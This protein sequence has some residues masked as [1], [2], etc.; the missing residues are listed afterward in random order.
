[1]D[2]AE[3]V[4]QI[5]ATRNLTLYSVSQQSAQIFGRSSRFYVP[6]NLYY[7]LADPSFTPT[8]HQLL[9]LS[10]ITNYRLFDWLAALGCDLEQ[11]PRLRLLIR[12]QRTTL[13]DSSVYDLFTWVPWFAGTT[14]GAP[15]LP[16]APLRRFMSTASPK[17]AMELLALNK[18]RFLYGKVGEADPYALP[19]LA[20]GSVVR[21]DPARTQSGLSGPG[22]NPE[23]LFFFVEYAAGFTCSRLAV[24]GKDRILLRSPQRPCAE[25]ELHLGRDAR[26]LGTIDA[27]IRPLADTCGARQMHGPI[28][29]RRPQLHL[30][31]NSQTTL[32]ELLRSRRMRAGFSF[33][34]ASLASRLIAERLSDVS[35]FAAPSTLSDYETLSEPPRHIQK[36]ITLCVLYGIEFREFLRVAGLPLDQEGRHPL[37]DELVPRTVPNRNHVLRNT[38]DEGAD[39][40]PSGLLGRLVQQWEEVPLFL[41]H[42]LAELAGLKKFSLSDVFW[43]GGETMPIHP[44]LT[45]ATFVAV[46]R[47][48]KKPVSSVAEASCGQPIYLILKRNG[49]Y[50]CGHSTLEE[51]NL[52]VHSYP[53]SPFGAQ[54]FGNGLDAEI[55][56]RVTAILRRLL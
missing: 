20:P 43:V 48:V 46:N 9:A 27:E 45:N 47:R 5:L 53:G 33:R 44:L 24:L 41:R 15:V 31:S 2:R 13:L 23:S 17:R 39:H 55:V 25:R 16:I 40:G 34:E 52:V 22:T 29:P 50:L 36:V 10:R 1:M 21:V 18:R 26:I 32:R 49:G 30:S 11:I 42:S 54:R 6:H 19:F 3:R 38:S 12:R 4:R 7:D 37:P 28:G 35:Y 51:T 8:I 56:G 14:T